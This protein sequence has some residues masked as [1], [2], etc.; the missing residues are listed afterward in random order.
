MQ[1]FF[2]ENAIIDVS[3]YAPIIQSNQELEFYFQK[4]HFST[5]GINSQSSDYHFPTYFITA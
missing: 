4:F 5:Y 1:Q 3:A 2:V